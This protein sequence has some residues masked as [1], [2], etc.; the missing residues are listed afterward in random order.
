MILLSVCLVFGLCCYS[1]RNVRPVIYVISLQ[2]HVAVGILFFFFSSRRRHT[3]CLSDWS[4]DVCSSDL[5][6]LLGASG[7][8]RR[9]QA[10]VARGLTRFVGRQQELAALHQALEQVAAGQ[11]QVVALVGEAGVGKSRLV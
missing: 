5:F 3:R 9:L 7:T 1:S 2:Y 11:G 8:R 10:A 4:S 6:E